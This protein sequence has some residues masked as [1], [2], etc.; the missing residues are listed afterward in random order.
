VTDRAWKRQERQ[1]A[2]RLG[3]HRNPNNGKRQADIHAGPFSVEHK[4]RKSLPAW[5]T[6]ALRQAEAGAEGKTP[7]VVLTEVRQGVKARRYVLLDF[8]DWA[9]WH[10]DEREKAF[11]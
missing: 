10:G 4:A 6:S 11:G 3:A 2:A 5:L 9:A 7:I 1:V 8:T